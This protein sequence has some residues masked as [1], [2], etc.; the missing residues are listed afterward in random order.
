M[1]YDIVSR[2]VIPSSRY[3]YGIS[4]YLLLI[5][6]IIMLA[7]ISLKIAKIKISNYKKTTYKY[8]INYMLFFI[9]SFFKFIYNILFNFKL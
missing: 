8:Q 3:T 9:L 7:S 5:M 2:G 4:Y 6:A 1:N